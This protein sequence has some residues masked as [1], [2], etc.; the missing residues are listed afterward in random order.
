[1][2][3]FRTASAATLAIATVC[4]GSSARAQDKTP[5]LDEPTYDAPPEKTM[6]HQTWTET[7]IPTQQSTTTTTSAE[8]VE[9]PGAEQ[10]R[11]YVPNRPA[12]ITG[13]A[14]FGAPYV[15]GVIVAAQSNLDADKRNYIPVVGPWLDLGQRPCAFGSACSTTDNLGSALLIGSGVLQGAGVV[16]M[17]TALAVPERTERRVPATAAVHVLPVPVTFT[18]GGGLGAAGTF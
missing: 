11:T 13:A 15:A 17:V 2:I 5:P 3:T 4:L 9:T 14:L 1:M 12:M 8:Y 7:Q 10:E 6:G 16:L 18:N